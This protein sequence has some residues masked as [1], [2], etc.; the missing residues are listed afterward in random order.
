MN[1]KQKSN[2][3]FINYYFLAL[4]FFTFLFL[5]LVN[6]LEESIFQSFKSSIIGLVT[7]W[8]YVGGLPLYYIISCIYILIVLKI[9]SRLREKIENHWA[10]MTIIIL[11]LYL[12]FAIP[13]YLYEGFPAFRTSTFYVPSVYFPSSY[14]LA[15][16]FYKYD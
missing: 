5:F 10:T 13:F 11:G 6:L 12:I 15:Y 16:L 9:R 7:I 2:F 1:K 3:F 8:V 14:F 4:S